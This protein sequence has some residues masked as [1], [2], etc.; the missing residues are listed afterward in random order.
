MP[1][2]GGEDWLPKKLWYQRGKR[3]SDALIDAS[4][5]VRKL[6]LTEQVGARISPWGKGDY[7]ITLG[8]LAEAQGLSLEACARSFGLV[9]VPQKREGDRGW[10]CHPW[11]GFFRWH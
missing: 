6:D 1:D 5:E 10:Q 9:Q 7:M 3:A 4:H 11:L 2:E 8:E